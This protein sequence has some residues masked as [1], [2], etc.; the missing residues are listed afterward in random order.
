MFF[1]AGG[2][3]NCEKIPSPPKKQLFLLEKDYIFSQFHLLPAMKNTAPLKKNVF[4]ST[5]RINLAQVPFQAPSSEC[6]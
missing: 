3:W 4:L 2:K 5:I 1:I 6:Q